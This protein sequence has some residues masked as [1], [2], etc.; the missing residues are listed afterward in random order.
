MATAGTIIPPGS[1]EESQEVPL[2]ATMITAIEEGDRRSMIA[3]AK[4]NPRSLVVFRRELDELVSLSESVA[5]EMTYSLPRGSG[6]IIGPSVRF[7]EAAAYCYRNLRAISEVVDVGDKQLTAQG[8]VFDAERNNGRA[9]RVNRNITGTRGRFNQDM[10]GVTGNAACSIAYRN[11][12]LHYI[13]KALWLDS[14][15][16]SKQVVTGGIETIG[17][18]RTDALQYFNAMG[19]TD[20]MV[21]NTLG[22][23]GLEDIGTDEL[24]AM[25]T[26]AREIKDHKRS[27]EDVFGSPLDVEIDATMKAIGWNETQKR[28]SRLNFAGNREGHLKHVQAEAA[29][30]GI[31]VELPAA[32]KKQEATPAAAQEG[33]T[34]SQPAAAKPSEPTTQPGQ[35]SNSEPQTQTTAPAGT[36]AG[37]STSAPASAGPKRNR[38]NW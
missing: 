21:F 23:R 36:T 20:V 28:L 6:Q 14:W 26:W 3:A 22:V 25:K 35:Q 27:I 15:E 11:A 17:K 1:E 24:V 16:K 8:T 38:A 31:T 37:D 18:K 29:K 30:A 10:I 13:P 34:A 12:V 9:E 19:V 33:D 5:A 32:A 7:A 4:A 2:S